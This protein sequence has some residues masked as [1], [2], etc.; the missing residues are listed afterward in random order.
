M[1][2]NLQ[3]DSS[4]FLSFFRIFILLVNL[5]SRVL[6]RI[7]L[8]AVRTILGLGL[9]GISPLLLPMGALRFR[10]HRQPRQTNNYHTLEPSEDLNQIGFTDGIYSWRILWST[11]RKL[12]WARF[13]ST[14]T[15]FHSDA[16][17]NWAIKPW[18]QLAFTAIFVQLLQFHRLFSVRFHFSY[19]FRQSPRF[20]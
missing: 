5:N 3:P 19:C 9:L 14:T 12:V 20:F 18:L 15:E 1:K 6:F 10:I 13:E 16:P 8:L 4:S 7:P 17:T 11:Y 2:K